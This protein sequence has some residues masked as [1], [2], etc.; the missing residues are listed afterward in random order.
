VAV[1][2]PDDHPGDALLEQRPPECALMLMTFVAL[3]AY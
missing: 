3:P 1:V 2:D